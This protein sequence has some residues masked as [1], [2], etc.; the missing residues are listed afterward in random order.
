M[1]GLRQDWVSWVPAL[2]VVLELVPMFFAPWMIERFGARRVLLF[3]VFA[4]VARYAFFALAPDLVPA[5]SSWLGVDAAS[6]AGRAPLWAAIAA[7]GLIHGP[8]VVGIYVVPPILLNRMATP[9]CRNSV[10]ALYTMLAV[11]CGVFA[12]NLG[13]GALAQHLGYPAVFLGA[14]GLVAGG[15]S[16]LL[17]GRWSEAAPRMPAAAEEAEA[18]PSGS[19]AETDI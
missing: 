5:W 6:V 4:Q 10:Q 3:A 9:T 1:Y 18:P 11:G 7:K 12:G 15:A 14:A 2:D 17:L 16:L 8:V 13:L 19:S